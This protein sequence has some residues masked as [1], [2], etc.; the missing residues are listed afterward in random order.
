MTTTTSSLPRPISVSTSQA[1]DNDGAGLWSTF[2]VEVGTPAQSARV[3]ISTAGNEV[4]VVVSQGC[5]DKYGSDCAKNR[6]GIFT[7]DNSTTWTNIGLFTLQLEM[8]LEYTGNGQYGHETVTLGY[9][10]SAPE[11]WQGVFGLD[12]TPSNFT[13][14]NDPQASYLATLRNQSRIPSTSW[15]Y[16]AG[17]AYR[18]SMVQGILTLGGYDASRFS[19]QNI[20][21]HFYD[22]VSRRFLVQLSA[23]KYIP[24]GL[25]TT[26]TTTTLASDPISLYIDSTVPYIYLPGAICKKFE[27]AFGLTWNDTTEIY[28]LND[29]MHT[30]LQNINPNITF[31][32]STSEGQSLDITLPYKAFDLNASFPVIPEGTINYFPLKRAQNDT[33]YTLGR[34]FLQ[35]AYL[36]ADY[37]R[38]EF[39]I[40][41][42]VWPSTF[43]SDIKSILPPSANSTSTNGTLTETHRHTST[44]VGTIVGGVVGGI[45]LIV[46]AALLFYLFVYRRRHPKPAA[47]ASESSPDVSTTDPSA[48]AAVAEADAA[49]VDPTKDKSELSG[50]FGGTEL[51]AAHEQDKRNAELAGT[52]I[53]GLEL[54]SPQPVGSE[55]DSPQIHEMLARESVVREMES[56]LGS[57]QNPKTGE[58]DSSYFDKDKKTKISFE[59]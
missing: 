20:T 37:D 50:N 30:S 55:L 8:N 40:A 26:T 15:G 27:S 54:A 42:C 59:E 21:L 5:P 10:G 52:P 46:G 41:P 57:G 14:L 29:T 17:A 58:E 33:Q 47:P 31:T 48:Y 56:P 1:W 23:I 11:F 24:T 25:S 22:A 6:G 13:T 28:T 18:Y 38:S 36:V 7:I 53:L 49:L 43:T 45:A 35:E 9:P 39:T 34:T 16:T 19:S 2:I 32:L 4:W 51:A 12:A 3:M 44:P